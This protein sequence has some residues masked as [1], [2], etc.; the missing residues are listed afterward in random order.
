MPPLLILALDRDDDLGVKTSIRSPVMGRDAVLDA[1]T[2]LALADPTE[3]DANGLFG[4]VKLC[5]DL[6][7]KGEEVEV[8]A[9]SGHPNV[10]LQSDRIIAAQL[11][12]VVQK[13]GALRALVVSDGADDEFLLPLIQSRLKLEAV[14]RVVVAQNVALKGFYYQLSKAMDSP[15]FGRQVLLPLGGMLLLFASFAAAGAVELA[16]ISVIGFLGAYLSLRGLGRGEELSIALHRTERF[17]SEGGAAL[18]FYL[19]AALVASLGVLVGFTDVQDEWLRRGPT[20]YATGP[21]PVTL[22]L[23]ARFASSAIWW[24]LGASV[25]LLIGRILGHVAAERPVW[26]SLSAMFYAG[27]GALMVWGLSQV[28][29][30]MGGISAETLP[31]AMR[32]FGF[33]VAATL[34]LAL[35]GVRMGRARK[36][37][38]GG[39]VPSSL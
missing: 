29:L 1:A 39:D 8:A 3:S 28:L 4:A 10:G 20:I 19:T 22:M 31:L 32:K 6:R 7:A 13:T 26:G 25:L 36:R 38:A 33:A 37:L 2:R 17:L 12:E 30:S 35:V 14:H 15:R 16:S 23:M 27:A 5:D 24:L 21:M 11:D 18:L 9:L 34:I